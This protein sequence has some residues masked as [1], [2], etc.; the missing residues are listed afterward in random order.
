MANNFEQTEE[1]LDMQLAK[2]EINHLEYIYKHSEE[3]KMAF[4]EFCSEHGY[5]TDEKAAYFFFEEEIKEEDDAI[6][7]G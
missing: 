4:L 6:N 3:K 1:L 7:N 5:D 2:G